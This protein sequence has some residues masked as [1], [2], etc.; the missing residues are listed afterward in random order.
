MTKHKEKL[1]NKLNAIFYK[2]YNTSIDKDRYK[3]H[4][5]DTNEQNSNRVNTSY[6]NTQ[7][8]EL[9]HNTHEKWCVNVADI[10]L[11]T[12]V[13]DVLN[14]AKNLILII[15]SITHSRYSI[16]RILKCF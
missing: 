3:E 16:L 9:Y 4:R 6:H 5:H 11:S 12:F 13:I 10:E 1:S 7:V 15:V 2:K 14:L 8:N